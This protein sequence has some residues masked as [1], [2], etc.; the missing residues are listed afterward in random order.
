M[1]SGSPSSLV[2]LAYSAL[3]SLA[4]IN[5]ICSCSPTSV[6][7]DIFLSDSAITKSAECDCARGTFPTIVCRVFGDRGD[8]SRW[9]ASA[10]SSMF[11]KLVGSVYECWWMSSKLETALRTSAGE[12]RRCRLP[13]SGRA[14]VG[15]STRSFFFSFLLHENE[16]KSSKLCVRLNL[17][18]SRV[19]HADTN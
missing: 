8:M 16:T 1:L 12:F 5:R 7:R 10:V 6:S 14:R 19:V 17:K 18:A 2:C 13:N 11:L 4:C 15:A 3:A 9:L